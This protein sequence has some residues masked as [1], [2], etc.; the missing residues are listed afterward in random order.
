MQTN[1]DQP[2]ISGE[3]LQSLSDLFKSKKRRIGTLLR[4]H[5]RNRFLRRCPRHDSSKQ[6]IWFRI[7]YRKVCEKR[8]RRLVV[9]VQYGKF[10]RRGQKCRISAKRKQSILEV[11]DGRGNPY[12]ETKG[13][14][15]PFSREHPKKHAYFDKVKNIL[16]ITKSPTNNH[17]RRKRINRW[18]WRPKKYLKAKRAEEA[19]GEKDEHTKEPRFVVNCV[20]SARYDKKDTTPS[21]ERETP[22]IALD[23]S[24]V[25]EDDIDKYLQE[26]DSLT[27]TVDRLTTDEKTRKDD[28]K[29]KMAEKTERNLS[30]SDIES[31]EDFGDST[32]RNGEPYTEPL[33][34]DSE[35]LCTDLADEL[36]E[37][38]EA[39]FLNTPPRP[40]KLPPIQTDE[41]TPTKDELPYTSPNGN[42]VAE[43]EQSD[44]G[45]DSDTAMKHR[46]N[47]KRSATPLR[48]RIR[49]QLSFLRMGKLKEP[50]LAESIGTVVPKPSNSSKLFALPVE[51]QSPG[52]IIHR[53]YSRSE[54]RSVEI[55]PA[56]NAQP[57]DRTSSAGRSNFIDAL[58]NK[59][60]PNQHSAAD[61]AL[62]DRP[63]ADEDFTIDEHTEPLMPSTVERPIADDD[64]TKEE[65][66]AVV[67]LNAA[68]LKMRMQNIAIDDITS[69]MSSDTSEFHGFSETSA[70]IAARALTI[71]KVVTL[72][73]TA[74]VK[75]PANVHHSAFVSEALDTFMK[76]NALENVAN[77]VSVA[78]KTRD[79]KSVYPNPALVTADSAPPPMSCPPRP[80][81]VARP[82]T[83]A[84]KRAQLAGNENDIRVRMLD[85][86]S[87]VYRALRRRGCA[88]GV[89][90]HQLPQQRVQQNNYITVDGVAALQEQRLPFTRHCWIA[91]SWLVT[92]PGQFY[93]QNVQMACGSELNVFGGR[94]GH[95]EVLAWSIPPSELAI[96]KGVRLP[97][98]VVDP[99]RCRSRCRPLSNVRIGKFVLRYVI[100]LRKSRTE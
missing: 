57:S 60:N 85:N 71:S 50:F 56:R 28:N 43:T 19:V 8:V 38:P 64:Y 67:P 39:E 29:V 4:D 78:V 66:P 98:T 1:T 68:K 26:K 34:A 63:I 52:A 69:D 12:D 31:D 10:R 75:P 21:T 20:S 80:L 93:Y 35:D 77:V 41:P 14:I 61:L 83:L 65:P 81:H 30:T 42:P 24:D 11:Q 45:I 46:P 90:Q 53:T 72:V 15:L 92:Q 55:K 86:E 16:I 13:C 36:D 88:L 96:E 2:T 94:G 49:E 3:P 84:E 76:E 95:E 89:G 87:H 33:T 9:T 59:F 74:V 32:P 73:P 54:R 97:D 51:C 22:T 7:M 58:Y 27:A 23:C 82:R 79:E 48:D 44:A 25:S 91:A 70:A 6:C 99:R 5:Y 62:R 18:S 40:K 37:L 100:T 47:R 17:R